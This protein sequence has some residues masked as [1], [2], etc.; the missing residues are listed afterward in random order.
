MDVKIKT[1]IINL[2][3]GPAAGKST[4][5]TGI[6]CLL[7]MHWVRCELV[8]EFAKDLVW[9]ER[10]KT[11]KNQQCVFG[12]QYHKIWRVLCRF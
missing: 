7:K 6:F 2:F 9:E 4:A 5:A 11:L 12:K 8:T 1:L 3:G 10:Y